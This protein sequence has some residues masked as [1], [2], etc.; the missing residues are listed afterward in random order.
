MRNIKLFTLLVC[1]SIT[2]ILILN[3]VSSATIQEPFFIRLGFNS[4][5]ATTSSSSPFSNSTSQVFLSNGTPNFL[6]ISNIFFV[7]GSNNR[8][9]ILTP[10]PQYPLDINGSV[11]I[12]PDNNGFTD[13]DG[14]FVFDQWRGSPTGISMSLWNDTAKLVQAI[15]GST[16]STGLVGLGDG[17][18]FAGVLNSDIAFSQGQILIDSLTTG[19]I[20]L[21]EST[22][23]NTNYIDLHHDS[24][25]G[26]N[27]VFYLY[28]NKVANSTDRPSLNI[29]GNNI[30]FYS[31]LN[32]GSNI[33]IQVL[34]LNDRRNVIVSNNLSVLNKAVFGTGNPGANQV[35]IN[36]SS[37]TNADVALYI[38]PGSSSNPNAIT[39]ER[40]DSTATV[41]SVDGTGIA[42]MNLLGIGTAEDG[43]NQARVVIGTPGR[44][45][46]VVTGSSSQTANLQEWQNDI[47]TSLASVNAT[48][49]ISGNHA[50]FSETIRSGN[51]IVQGTGNYTGILTAQSG[52]Q[53]LNSQFIYWGADTNTGIQGAN[54]NIVLQ[55]FSGST[56]RFYDISTGTNI[57]ISPSTGKLQVPNFEGTTNSYAS[58][59]SGFNSVAGTAGGDGRFKGGDASTAPNFAGGNGGNVLIETGYH[60]NNTNGN[61]GIPG[62]I[63]F[64]TWLDGNKTN[65]TEV[66]RF[67]YNGSLII[68]GNGLIN[69][70]RYKLNVIGDANVTG[71]FYASG[72]FVINATNG[73]IGIRRTVAQTNAS[74]HIYNHPNTGQSSLIVEAGNGQSVD[75][76]RV[77]AESQGSD[78][79]RIG[80]TGHV[81]LATNNGLWWGAGG[82]SYSRIL[83]LDSSTNTTYLDGGTGGNVTI[84]PNQGGASYEFPASGQVVFPGLTLTNG[85]TLQFRN[86]SG[87]PHMILQSSG[88]DFYT[89]APPGAYFIFRM[90]DGATESFR[91]NTNGQVNFTQNVLFGTGNTPN[92][93]VDVRGNINVSNTVYIKN[94]SID[95]STFAYNMSDG[96]GGL[97][98][99]QV[100]WS[101]NSV[102]NF[103]NTGFPAV[104]NISNTLIINGT[105][106]T[107]TINGTLISKGHLNNN[108]G[109]SDVRFN[110]IYSQFLFATGI[111][112][113]AYNS[114]DNSVSVFV[115]SGTTN[116]FYDGA[117]VVTMTMVPG[118]LATFLGNVNVSQNLT[119]GGKITNY[120]ANPTEGNGISSIVNQTYYYNITTP[121]MNLTLFTPTTSG[122]YRV[123]V[124]HGSMMSD[125]SASLTTILTWTDMNGGNSISPAGIDFPLYPQSFS[126]SDYAFVQANKPI[127]LNVTLA[128]YLFDAPSYSVFATVERLS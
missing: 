64:K 82:T 52:V 13:S 126:A 8:T 6:N 44:K 71:G 23:G 51:S 19:A 61:Q 22:A 110:N 55:G 4:T 88:D 63:S 107:V 117:G 20:I 109:S 41:F 39:V 57:T 45:G 62:F 28:T 128:G 92:Q 124:R 46:L 72:T 121:N 100:V 113:D 99:S 36:A 27:D 68:G 120:N 87:S 69:N 58:N 2:A 43:T 21:G 37:G 5:V 123:S 81:Y 53:L 30:T 17:N 84:R 42:F 95:L 24:T 29:G 67:T 56:F 40:R 77:T 11:R 14:F 91:I 76:V 25:S 119:V 93:K 106:Q 111:R 103:I 3:S 54:S 70:T 32:D 83:H 34:Q 80:S 7:N 49:A 85:Q 102:Q 16:Y 86:T 31:G 33:G 10:T 73:N 12:R 98:A 115:H 90:S 47:G 125:G 38:K 89:S 59:F 96:S 18:L 65:Q 9:G 104:T 60:T 105:E 74:L 108:I 101:N 15:S 116:S 35:F 75:I 118:K 112:A 79:F 26:A 97:T 114:A 1:L 127:L 50:N 66:G 48:G 122:L 78:F 94:G